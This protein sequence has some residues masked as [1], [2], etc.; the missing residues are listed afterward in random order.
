LILKIQKRLHHIILLH[1][2]KHSLAVVHFPALYNEK[3]R[4]QFSFGSHCYPYCS[5]CDLAFF[6]GVFYYARGI[7]KKSRRVAD[8][9][10]NSNVVAVVVGAGSM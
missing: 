2:I 4:T 3:K 5:L 6:C 9:S 7:S 10:A 8:W 1:R